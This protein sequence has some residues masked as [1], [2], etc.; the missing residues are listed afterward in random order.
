MQRQVEIRKAL[1]HGAH[2]LLDLSGV[3]H[4]GRVAEGDAAHA[5]IDV[6]RNAV[7]DLR[8]GSDALERTAE[9]GRDRS[10]DADTTATKHFEYPAE[11]GER[12]GDA[13]ADVGAVVRF[14]RR[15]DEHDL[16]QFC[17]QCALRAARV[18]HQRDIGDGRIAA[19]PRHHLGRVAEVWHGLGRYERGRLDLGDTGG[20]KK[21]D[22]LDLALGR[23]PRR[24]DLETVAGD[25]IVN[26]DALAHAFTSSFLRIYS[27]VLTS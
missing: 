11:T 21:I 27:H 5:K 12:F 24:L 6:A 23:Y 20:R 8:F 9:C 10:D 19:D 13:A 7:D 25:D 2:E 4:S 15:H 18:R 26:E 22:D 17:G 3:G 16:V 1:R 14:R